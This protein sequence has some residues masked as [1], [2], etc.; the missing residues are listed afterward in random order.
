MELPL[1]SSGTTN[2][3]PINILLVDRDPLLRAHSELK[4]CWKYTM[5]K[6]ALP[7]FVLQ[8]QFMSRSQ[9]KPFPI[10]T[11]RFEAVL[12]FDMFHPL[13]PGLL[14]VCSGPLS[15]WDIPPMMSLENVEFRVR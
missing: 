8:F 5:W 1:F 2:F 12:F 13:I 6:G 15:Q 4:D 11:K 3:G 9:G 14:S 7:S 10:V